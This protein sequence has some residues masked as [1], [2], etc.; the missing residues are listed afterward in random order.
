[1]CGSSYGD[2]SPQ[3]VCCS[4]DQGLIFSF[5]CFP[6]LFQ[7]TCS[8]NLFREL[9]ADIQG[10][11]IRCA[12]APDAKANQKVW[13]PPLRKGPLPSRWRPQEP[14][15][16]NLKK[17][18]FQDIV[19]QYV[20]PRNGST[21]RNPR[22]ANVKRKRCEVCTTFDVSCGKANQPHT[23]Q[24]VTYEYTLVHRNIR[25]PDIVPVEI[26]TVPSAV[27]EDHAWS[28]RLG[29]TSIAARVKEYRAKPSGHLKAQR[30]TGR[31]EHDCFRI[32][33]QHKPSAYFCTCAFVHAV[34]TRCKVYTSCTN[35]QDVL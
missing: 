32:A 12:H 27:H 31:V 33:F 23:T 11:G 7:G 28:W 17:K 2:A 29:R 10:T 26:F 5:P 35:K 21:S 14:L 1:M 18:I 22:R 8:G 15:F 3:I 9:S 34:R 13:A 6:E 24:P 4:R 25:A 16:C 30:I 19:Q 20:I